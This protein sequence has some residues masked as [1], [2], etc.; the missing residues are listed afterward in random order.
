MRFA[1]S[2]RH[3]TALLVI[4][5]VLANGLL[6]SDAFF[7]SEVVLERPTQDD[8]YR[9]PKI[10]QAPSGAIIVGATLKVGHMR[11]AGGEEV[12]HYRV[13]TDDGATWVATSEC[14]TADVVDRQT[15][16]FWRTAGSWP[17]VNAEG[18]RMTE[19]W[20]VKQP[21]EGNRDRRLGQALLQ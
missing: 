2:K 9:V 16:K 17:K 5:T 19:E 4:S 20:M 10:I 8:H 18:K 7:T 14:Q 12:V 13:S 15:G 6:A 3:I 11:D 1:L 21:P